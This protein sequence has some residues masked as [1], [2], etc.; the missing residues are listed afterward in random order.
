MY[1]R[2]Q[3]VSI[4]EDQEKVE[5]FLGKDGPRGVVGIAEVDELGIVGDRVGYAAQVEA[6]FAV[7][8]DHGG[9]HP[10]SSAQDRETEEGR[11]GGEHLVA[12]L[13]KDPNDAT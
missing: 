5:L 2:S 3:T 1:Q 7:Q 13:Q 11:V 6:I 10:A 12:L 9:L 8:G 4:L